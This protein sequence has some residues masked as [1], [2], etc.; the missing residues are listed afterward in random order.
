MKLLKWLNGKQVQVR[1]GLE[2]SIEQLAQE[3]EEFRKQVGQFL[4]RLI[5]H[6]VF[7]NGNLVVAHA[8]LKEEMQGRGSGAVRDF[9]LYGE[10]TGE[11]DELACLCDRTGRQNIREGQSLYTGTHRYRMRNG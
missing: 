2:Q 8:G 10:T 11:T 5:S 7:D 3:S 9:C 4:D 1:H 6:Y